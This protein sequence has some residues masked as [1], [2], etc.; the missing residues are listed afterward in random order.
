MNFFFVGFDELFDV[1][2]ILLQFITQFLQINITKNSYCVLIISSWRTN[3][4]K[5]YFRLH[6]T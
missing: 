3:K 1:C 2:E 4:Q 5:W 6:R